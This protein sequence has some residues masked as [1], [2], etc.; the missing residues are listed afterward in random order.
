V[1]GKASRRKSTGPR[2]R[3]ARTWPGPDRAARDPS[4]A[5]PIRRPEPVSAL[6]YPAKPT[7]VNTWRRNPPGRDLSSSD[8]G[9]WARARNRSEG[10]VK[11]HHQGSPPP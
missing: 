8:G 10:G 1:T 3:R 7:S 2:T 9:R 4:A 5:R 11:G 6:F